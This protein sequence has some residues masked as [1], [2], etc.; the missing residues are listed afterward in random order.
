MK[1]VTVLALLGVC[2]FA[3]ADKARVV[4]VVSDSSGAAISRA[5]VTAKET[6]TGAERQVTSDDKGYYILS[7]LEPAD[8][9]ITA[10]S[11]SL[12]PAEFTEFHLSVGQERTLNIV[13][14]PSTVTSEVTV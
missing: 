2:L 4:G 3:Q 5:S 6:K 1:H 8:Y 9:T 7:N 13:L 14:K 10:K 12:G 11:N